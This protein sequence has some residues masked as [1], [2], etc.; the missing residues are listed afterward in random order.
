MKRKKRYCPDKVYEKEMVSETAM[1]YSITDDGYGFYPVDHE[2]ESLSETHPE[3]RRAGARAMGNR[4]S[5]HKLHAELM[6]LFGPELPA[7]QA[8]KLLRDLAG[9][10]ERN[11]LV[12]GRD[13]N[14]GFVFVKTS[15]K[16]RS[17]HRIRQRS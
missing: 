4:P 17:S 1:P 10:L 6:V 16:T 15:G 14:S 5:D 3:E 2:I 12:I 7:K 11:G 9:H 8:I 13:P